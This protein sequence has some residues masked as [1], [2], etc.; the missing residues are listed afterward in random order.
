ME[1]VLSYF[2]NF[3]QYVCKH[4]LVLLRFE[5]THALALNIHVFVKAFGY[6]TWQPLTLVLI[7][8]H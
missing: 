2:R 7:F 5:S 8:Q 4:I 3:F 1:M 6:H